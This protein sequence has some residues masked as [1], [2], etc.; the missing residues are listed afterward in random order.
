M[1]LR[2]PTCGTLYEGDVKFCAKDGGRLLPV[3]GA[4]VAPAAGP[5]ATAP[6]AA[7]EA[8]PKAAELPL[9]GASAAT[10]PAVAE[11]AAPAAPV[12]MFTYSGFQR[13]SLMR[14]TSFTY[15]SSTLAGPVSPHLPHSMT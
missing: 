1:K 6:R 3:G 2:C 12:T 9:D 5:G 4:P 8:A 15:Q 7:A 10:T 14:R 13:R 11:A